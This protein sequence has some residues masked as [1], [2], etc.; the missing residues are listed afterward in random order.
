MLEIF[1]RRVLSVALRRLVPLCSCPPGSSAIAGA[2]STA[3]LRASTSSAPLRRPFCLGEQQ[4]NCRRTAEEL[5]KNCRRTAEELQ[6][7]CRRIAEEPQMNYSWGMF[8]YRK[9][10]VLL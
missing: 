7:N 3:R 10:Y 5:Q 2:S 8:N 4:K 1:P 6:K 9:H